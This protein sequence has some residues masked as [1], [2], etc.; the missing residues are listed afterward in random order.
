MADLPP[1]AYLDTSALVKLVVPEPET[2]SLRAELGR[3]PRRV[4][5]TLCRAELVRACVRIDQAT[6]DRARALLDGLFLVSVTGPVLDA[7]AD[8]EPVSLRTLDAIHLATARTLE[9]GLG[10]FVTY[11]QRLSAA[12][13]EVGFPVLAPR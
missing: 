7:A 2:S 6:R 12:A 10:V 13:L 8:L 4:S 3:W 1:M 11:D 5:S 9:P